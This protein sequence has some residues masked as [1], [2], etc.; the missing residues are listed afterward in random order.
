MVAG[1]GTLTVLGGGSGAR[2]AHA[3]RRQSVSVR[4]SDRPRDYRPPRALF[5]LLLVRRGTSR[6]T[7]ARRSAKT[8]AMEVELHGQA[9]AEQAL[10]QAI[11]RHRAPPLA[12]ELTRRGLGPY[13]AYGEMLLAIREL[14]HRGASL[15]VIGK[16]V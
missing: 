7:L 9:G 11:D 16:S 1:G 8:L 2:G 3:V 15:E 12:L 4:W 10:A 5:V 14:S 13:R 6:S